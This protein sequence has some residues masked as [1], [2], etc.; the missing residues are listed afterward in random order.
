[1]NPLLALFDA[2]L[3]IGGATILWR[4]IV[5]NTFGIASAIGGMKRVV[6]AWPVGIAGMRCCSPCSWA[7][8]STP[9]RS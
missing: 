5:G 1:M 2:E 3:H 8:C 7:R 6:W 9:H 4:E